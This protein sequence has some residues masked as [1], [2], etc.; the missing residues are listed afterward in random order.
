MPRTRFQA[1]LTSPWPLVGLLVGLL[2][3][4]LVR[5]LWRDIDPDEIEALHSAWLV[6]SG[7][8]P[9]LDFFQQHNPFHY[10][11]LAG[12]IGVFGEGSTAILA[13]RLLHFGF[14]LL[15]LLAVLRI[16][17]DLFGQR[18]AL[19]SVILLASSAVFANKV[20]EVRPDVPQVLLGLIALG[21]FLRHALDPRARHLVVGSVALGLAFLFLQKAVFMMLAIGGLSLLRVAMG[22]MRGRDLAL[23][24]ACVTATVAPFYAWLFASGAWEL[25]Y[26]SNFEV[27]AATDGGFGPIFFLVA[28]VRQ[29]TVLWAFAA[30]GLVFFLRSARER[31]LGLVAVAMLLSLWVAHRPWPYYSLSVLPLL[32]LLA[33]RA[34]DRSFDARP[35]LAHAMVLLG[36]APGLY[37]LAVEP[38]ATN[39]QRLATIDR[40]VALTLPTDR[41][42]D[43]QCSFNVFRPDLDY[44]WYALGE[45]GVL[46]RFQRFVEHPYDLAEL[47]RERRPVVISAAELERAGDPGLAILYEPAL[48]DDELML[49]SP[50][51]R[52]GLAQAYQATSGTSR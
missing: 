36:A 42:H 2:A 33:G 9:Y 23:A 40:V 17:L 30:L 51:G 10:Y 24:L 52:N 31:E 29:S 49:L 1:V 16:G 46:Q 14:L 6:S 27:N 15:I 44:V 13:C 32:A 21:S 7:Q 4:L 3:L 5:S 26:A 45:N 25:Y 35:E 50:E 47:V 20:I 37:F 38:Y 8:R 43:G 34:L 28:N 39:E 48:I 19:A 12:V 41:V 18:A 11:S 22:R